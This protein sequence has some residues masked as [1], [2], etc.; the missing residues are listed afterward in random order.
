MF[1]IAKTWNPPKC[2]AMIDWAKKMWH[3]YTMEYYAVIK[4]D[5]FLSF[6]G[7]R[8]NQETIIFS[9]LKQEQKIKYC[10]FSLIGGC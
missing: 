8:M 5:E 2:P 4:K 6:V 1:T 9:K 7:T 3:R 10:M